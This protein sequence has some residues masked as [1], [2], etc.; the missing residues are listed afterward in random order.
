MDSGHD[1]LL[2]ESPGASWLLR[3]PKKL[4]ALSDCDGLDR[5]LTGLESG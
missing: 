2:V 1:L 3:T 5:V 4:W